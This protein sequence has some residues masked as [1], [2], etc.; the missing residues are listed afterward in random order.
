M[1]I[2]H[3]HETIEKISEYACKEACKSVE[4][5][6]TKELGEAVDMI[7]D[8]AEAEYYA[9]IS[10]AMEESEKEDEEEAKRIMRE[11]KDQYGEEEGERRFYDNYRY[12]KTGRFAPKGRGTRVG[13]RGYTEMMMPM[14]YM[15]PDIYRDNAEWDRDMDRPMGRMYYSG[16]GSNSGMSGGN[17]GGSRSGGNTGGN[18]GNTSGGSSSR[19]YSD[20]YSDGMNEG[21]RRG[22]E[23]GMRDGEK[24][25]RNSQ[26]DSRY[27]RARRGY[28]E[29]K[30]MH[31]SNSAED[32]QIRMKEAEKTAN[33][34]LDALVEMVEDES[35]EVKSM[36][37]TK[38]MSKLQKIS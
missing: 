17:M 24:M 37:K 30:A 7:K 31:G 18:S 13:R 35:P 26:S 8:L 21:T 11:M 25:G 38:G 3:I 15:M 27:D 5:I 36:I 6:D 12:M 9:R 16:S 4:E 34:F 2:K 33:I 28:E 23:D 29:A 14:D 1:H 20:G 19:G 10:K 22:Y 32:K